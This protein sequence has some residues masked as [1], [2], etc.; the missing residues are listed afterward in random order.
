MRIAVV[1]G[2]AAQHERLAV[3]VT[4][5]GAMQAPGAMT[6]MCALARREALAMRWYRLCIR[7]SVP[8]VDNER[9]GGERIA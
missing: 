4:D 9:A 6:V 7:K 1:P 5:V 3:S 8:V 2:V